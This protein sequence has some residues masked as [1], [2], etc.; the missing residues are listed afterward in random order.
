MTKIYNRKKKYTVKIDSNALANNIFKLNTMCI[1]ILRKCNQTCTNCIHKHMKV[2]CWQVV[3]KSRRV[4]FSNC[5]PDKLSFSSEKCTYLVP[6]KLT[7]P[8]EKNLTYNITHLCY[9]YTTYTSKNHNPFL[10]IIL[11]VILHHTL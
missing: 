1:C 3:S 11:H 10:L 7:I 6:I 8:I 4:L 9:F 5:T 2:K